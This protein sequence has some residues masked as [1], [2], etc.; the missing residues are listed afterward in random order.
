M[1]ALLDQS[2]RDRF[3]AA[4]GKNISVIAPAGVGKT[5]SI[6]DRIVHLARQPGAET[7]LPR[8]IVVTYSVRAAQEMQQRTRTAIREAKVSS[9]VQRAFQQRRRFRGR[10]PVSRL[11]EK[12]IRQPPHCDAIVWI[13]GQQVFH[14]RQRGQRLHSLHKVESLLTFRD[15]VARRLG[16]RTCLRIA[17][18]SYQ[19]KN[20]YALHR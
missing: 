15:Q 4:L 10:G 19:Q 8:L 11:S 7:V 12:A 2:E 5:R 17:R 18:R 14:Q 1:S 16:G 3:V 13:G 20:R 9:R 6:V